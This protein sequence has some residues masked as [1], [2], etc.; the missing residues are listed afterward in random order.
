MDAEQHVR[1]TIDTKP[2]DDGEPIEIVPDTDVWL[3]QSAAWIPVQIFDRIQ[4]ELHVYPATFKSR[5][6]QGLASL[7]NVLSRVRNVTSFPVT[8]DMVKEVRNICF[9][10][11]HKVADNSALASIAKAEVAGYRQLLKNTLER[12]RRRVAVVMESQRQEAKLSYK[13]REAEQVSLLDKCAVLDEV[14]KLCQRRQEEAHARAVALRTELLRGEEEEEA[15]D[16]FEA[17]CGYG[18]GM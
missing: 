18:Y 11:S 14:A 9:G 12:Q 2:A 15:S 1:F 13:M 10:Y 3:R 16:K 8:E 5:R 6:P 4:Q 7:D 17:S